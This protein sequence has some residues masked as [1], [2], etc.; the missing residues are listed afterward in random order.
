M[1]TPVKPRANPAENAF[2]VLGGIDDGGESEVGDED[3]AE[4][5]GDGGN[6]EV[7]DNQGEG[8]RARFTLSGDEG[9]NHHFLRLMLLLAE[10]HEEAERSS[11]ESPGWGLFV[12]DCIG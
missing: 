8:N 2:G 11:I 7:K 10:T 1:F 12:L 4:E 9:I 3:V 5:G 6:E